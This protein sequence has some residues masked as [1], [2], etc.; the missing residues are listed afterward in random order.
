MG[1]FCPHV[2]FLKKKRSKSFLDKDEVDG[3]IGWN[4]VD[5]KDVEQVTIVLPLKSKMSHKQKPSYFP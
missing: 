5:S 4:N 2:V 3:T 1:E